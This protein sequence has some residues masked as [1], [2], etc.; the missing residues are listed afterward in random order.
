MNTILNR[1]ERQERQEGQF[2]RY[3]HLAFLAVNAFLLGTLNRLLK[4]PFFSSL[5]YGTGM[6]RRF[7]NTQVFEKR[8][9]T[10]ITLFVLRAEKVQDGLFQQPVR[11]CTL[12]GNKPPGPTVFNET[13]I[14]IPT[15]TTMLRRAA[16]LFLTLSLFAPAVPAAESP[17]AAKRAEAR[18][19]AAASI[20]ADVQQAAWIRDGQSKHVI[21]VFFDPN[22]PYCHKVYEMLRPAVQGGAVELRWI[23]LGILMTTSQGKAATMLEAKDPTTALHRNERGFSQETGA[24]GGLE[25]EPLPREATLAR[26]KVHH[27]LLQ[28]SGNEAVP[29]LVYRTRDGRADLVQGAPP[30]AFLEKLLKELE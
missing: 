17:A 4:N 18:S 9:K 21:Y 25:E 3:K 29:T 22:C 20:L 16:T 11:R 27:A 28:R 26:L 12:I 6:C 10:K 19:R 2:F 7:S 13:P 14:P 24:F 5:W 15:R 30:A 23:V 1:Q 8:S